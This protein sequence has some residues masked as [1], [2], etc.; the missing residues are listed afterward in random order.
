MPR[1]PKILKKIGGLFSGRERERHKLQKIKSRIAQAAGPKSPAR[2]KLEQIGK[3]HEIPFQSLAVISA[4]AGYTREQAEAAFRE[5]ANHELTD[6]KKRQTYVSVML[7][8]Y[9]KEMKPPNPH[10]KARALIMGTK[11]KKRR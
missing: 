6:E 10:V 5:I 7:E 8:G 1:V 2:E 11:P 3:A 9:D 4:R